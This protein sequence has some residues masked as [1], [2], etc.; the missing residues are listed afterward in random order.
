M[1]IWSFSLIKKITILW[2]YLFISYKFSAILNNEKLN[3]LTSIVRV[4]MTILM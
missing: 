3:N 2:L 4:S 1:I